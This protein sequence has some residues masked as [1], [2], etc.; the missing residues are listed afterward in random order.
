MCARIAAT[1]KLPPI[2]IGQMLEHLP[3]G[4]SLSNDRGTSLSNDRF[5][6]GPYECI[7]ACPVSMGKPAKCDWIDC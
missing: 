5:W 1:S 6:A 3:C 7:T 4:T 2:G